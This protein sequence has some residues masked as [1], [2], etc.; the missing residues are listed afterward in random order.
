M[1]FLLTLSP[2][3]LLGKM[4]CDLLEVMW[5]DHAKIFG[6][7]IGSLRGKVQY[8]LFMF[9]FVLRQCTVKEYISGYI[10]TL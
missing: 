8:I 10:K 4:E 3:F 9:L 6:E 1:Y 7:A 5:T 2:T